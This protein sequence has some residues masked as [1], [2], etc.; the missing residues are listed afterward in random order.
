MLLW[1][2]AAFSSSILVLLNAYKRDYIKSL[3]KIFELVH[4]THM[5]QVL[6]G[7]CKTYIIKLCTKTGY[8]LFGYEACKWEFN[9]LANRSR[10]HFTVKQYKL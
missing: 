1:S 2:R 10:N 3:T 8:G 6:E 5:D 4:L 7:G 9:S